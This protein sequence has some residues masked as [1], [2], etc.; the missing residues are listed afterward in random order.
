MNPK[1]LWIGDKIRCLQTGRTGRFDGMHSNGNMRLKDRNGRI[2]LAE[3]DKAELYEDEQVH[4]PI[5]EFED[6]VTTP[7]SLSVTEIDLHIEVLRPDLVNA[8]PERIVDIQIKCFEEFLEKMKTKRIH[9]CLVIHG[10]GK[11]VLKTTVHQILK[12]DQA[13]LQYRLV[14]N[15]GATEVIFY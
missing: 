13:V 10:R 4:E 3:S 14:N 11:G 8:L 15:D 9:K 6:E 1:D 7:F 12:A 5:I 2:F